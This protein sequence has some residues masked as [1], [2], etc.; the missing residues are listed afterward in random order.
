ML[1]CRLDT[2]EA[3]MELRSVLGLSPI[4]S[5]TSL[6]GMLIAARYYFLDSTPW[7]WY[8]LISSISLIS[9]YYIFDSSFLF[10]YFYLPSLTTFCACYV[11]IPAS[12]SFQNCI[13]LSLAA[14]DSSAT[15]RLFCCCP[16]RKSLYIS[17]MRRL[18]MSD[19]CLSSLA[20]SSLTR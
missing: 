6:T 8:L 10:Y 11:Y 12:F 15:F 1:C 2:P 14:W 16:V 13:Y 9:S 17:L 3:F 19:C 5:A 18:C 4:A 7:E 20:S